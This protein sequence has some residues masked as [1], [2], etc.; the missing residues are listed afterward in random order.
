MRTVVHDGRGPLD[1]G[2]TDMTN[3]LLLCAV[4]H[5]KHHN[6]ECTV[7][8]DG[9]GRFTVAC[10]G[11]ILPSH[12][13]TAIAASDPPVEDETGDIDETAALTRWDGTRLTIDAIN[14]YAQHLN[15]ARTAS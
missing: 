12:A 4:Y 9:H 10:H 13:A 7:T 8:G 11:R 15:I 1:D 3:L 2:R 14:V 6:A 5:H